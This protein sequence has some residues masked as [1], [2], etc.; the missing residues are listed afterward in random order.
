MP[1]IVD[2]T[3]GAVTPNDF[4]GISGHPDA[5]PKNGTQTRAQEAA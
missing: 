1:L 5:A 2:A 4:F 3:G